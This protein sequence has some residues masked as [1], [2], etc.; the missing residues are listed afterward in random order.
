MWLINLHGPFPE[1][2]CQDGIDD[3]RDGL[4]DC[5]VDCN[6]WFFCQPAEVICDDGI[7]NNFNGF[8]DCDDPDCSFNQACVTNE[9]ACDNGI[10]DDN[11][12]YRLR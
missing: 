12:D 3:D 2:D 7:D 4:T 8:V 11:D 5:D 10:D 6:T 9:V 1:G